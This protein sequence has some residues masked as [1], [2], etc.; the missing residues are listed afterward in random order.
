[1]ADELGD[2]LRE[3]IGNPF[4]SK[5]MILKGEFDSFLDSIIKP[6][7]EIVAAVRFWKLYL[8]CQIHHE[9]EYVVSIL[10]IFRT[11]EF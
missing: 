2:D 1:M 5:S 7:H 9:S 4:R 8:R 3:L 11:N 6:V 10:F